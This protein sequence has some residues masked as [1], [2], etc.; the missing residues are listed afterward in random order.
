M[1]QHPDPGEYQEE[2]E[3]DAPV[4]PGS[5]KMPTSPSS[6]ASGIPPTRGLTDGTPELGGLPLFPSGDKTAQ[7]TPWLAF[8]R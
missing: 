4:S 7:H 2:L 1:T 3:A 6:R 8:P 5:P